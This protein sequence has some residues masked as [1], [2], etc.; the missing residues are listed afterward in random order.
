VHGF[1]RNLFVPFTGLSFL[2]HRAGDYRHFILIID[3]GDN[4]AGNY[5]KYKQTSYFEMYAYNCNPRLT[6]LGIYHPFYCVILACGYL[7]GK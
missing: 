1:L 3:I 4:I 2:R 5:V 6:L 7:P